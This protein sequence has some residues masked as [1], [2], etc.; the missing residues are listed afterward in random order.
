M[1]T[2]L[3]PEEEDDCLNYT[4]WF[5]TH[6]P[7]TESDEVEKLGDIISSSGLEE[8]EVVKVECRNVESGVS[9]RLAGER[10]SCN[11]DEGLI[12]KHRRQ[13]DNNCDD[14]EVRLATLKKLERCG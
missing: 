9:S 4:D 7:T 10:V 6:I 11:S 8:D 3:P 13:D 12:C 14:Y 2:T 1:G 5:N